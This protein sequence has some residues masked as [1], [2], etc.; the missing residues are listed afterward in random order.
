VHPQLIAATH[1]DR[2]A[3]IT[4]CGETL[5]YA[6]LAGSCWQIARL[7]RELGL[8]AGDHIALCMENGPEMLEIL[9][10]AHSAGLLYTACSTQLTPDELAFIVND[11]DASVFIASAGLADR[12]AAILGRTPRVRRRFSVGGEI[13][14][15]APL[16]DALAGLSH[17]PLPEAV[18]G[19]DMLYSSGTTGRPKGIKPSHVRAPLYAPDMYTE[20]TR[21]VWGFEDGGVYLSPAPLYHAAP[22]RGCLSVHRMGG[23]VVLMR[24]FDAMT[25]LSLIDGHR[26]THSQF[27]PTMFIR[28]LRLGSDIRNQYDVS[29]LK[30]VTHAAAPC[31][32]EVKRAMIEWWG[33]II[34]EYYGATEACGSTWITSQE[35]LAHPGSVGRALVGTLH[36]VDDDDGTELP[37]GEIG[38]IY[39][40]DGPAFEYHKDSEKTAEAHDTRGWATCGDIGRLD[41]DGYLYLTD[42]KAHMIISGGVNVYPQE[43]ENLLSTHPLVLDAAVFGIP[44]D[45]LGEQV[46]AVVQ[47]VEMPAA[48]GAKAELEATLIAHC[49]ASLAGFKCP[50]SI[51]FRAELPRHDTG[52]LYKRLLVEEYRVATTSEG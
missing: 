12:A 45:D 4:E 34:N 42:R 27:V 6:R 2:P 22:L 25:A 1:P 39:F 19:A 35:W 24:R 10:G 18:A 14:G 37:P 40:S 44:D 28:M 51:D 30:S 46:K 23:T 32:I 15:H 13:D 52:K 48:E 16:A 50:R 20:V 41:P 11:C 49:R 33:P 21:R 31:P 38:T 9:W 47:P 17:A 43:A 36:I 26:V 7:L 3:L 8:R 29:S 5:T